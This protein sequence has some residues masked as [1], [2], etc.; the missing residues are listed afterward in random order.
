MTEATE[1]TYMC[2]YEPLNIHILILAYCL[3][4]DR[5]L[6]WVQLELLVIVLDVNNEYCNLNAFVSFST[7]FSL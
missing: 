7:K 6:K 5:S 3:G 4:P 1:H 2:I